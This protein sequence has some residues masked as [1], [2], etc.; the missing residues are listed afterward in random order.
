M[1]LQQEHLLDKQQVDLA[2]LAQR[3][4]Q[5]A[6]GARGYQYPALVALAR[7]TVCHRSLVNANCQLVIQPE[8]TASPTLKPLE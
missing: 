8:A 4:R 7:A 1:L 6:A 3:N 2:K 5:A